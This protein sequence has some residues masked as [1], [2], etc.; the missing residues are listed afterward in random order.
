MSVTIKQIAAVA[1]LSVPT[2]SRILNNDTELFRPETREKVLKAARDLGYRPNSYRM[3]LRTKRFNA[4]GLLLGTKQIDGIASGGVMRTLLAELHGRNQH[5]LV[6]EVPECQVEGTEAA[7]KM[8]REWSVDG[9]LMH[10]DENPSHVVDQLI[11]DNKI[12]TV[13]FNSR[14][15]TDSVY[16]DDRDGARDATERLIRLGHKNVAFVDLG[17]SPDAARVERRAG[18]EAAIQQGGAVTQL[19]TPGHAV[20]QA[21]RLD[22]L[23]NWLRTHR[24]TS[25]TAALC[26]GRGEASALFTAAVSNGLSVPRDLSIIAI[27]DE[28][29]DDPGQRITT[30]VLPESEM[31]LQALAALAEKITDPGRTAPSRALPLS[32]H[33]GATLAPPGGV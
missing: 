15:E 12:P 13:W 31:A 20:P 8:L 11:R 28:P 6:G 14:R 3:A 23:S 26:A 32:Y 7:P 27:H 24:E 33:E 2:V 30:M 1:G 17:G 21:D 4:I 19:V 29:L 16:P 25:S 22:Y 18:Y 10:C 5:L 9:M